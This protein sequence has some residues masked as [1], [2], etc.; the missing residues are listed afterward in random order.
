MKNESKIDMDDL[1]KQYEKMRDDMIETLRNRLW[2]DWTPHRYQ[3]AKYEQRRRV[4]D[5]SSDTDFFDIEVKNIIVPNKNQ[6][7]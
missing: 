6:L 5:I 4:S 3:R 2:G 7:K 1:V